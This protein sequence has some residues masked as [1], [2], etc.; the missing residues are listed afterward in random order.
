M[1]FDE[2]QCRVVLLGL[3]QQEELGLGG[4]LI[5]GFKS[6]DLYDSSD[7]SQ[8]IYNTMFPTFIAR[9]DRVRE[10]AAV[11]LSAERCK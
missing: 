1:Q 2:F 5:V 4:I 6:E 7:P 8:S 10:V 9:L 11:D 3:E